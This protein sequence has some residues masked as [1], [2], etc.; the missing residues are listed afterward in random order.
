MEVEEVCDIEVMEEA[1]Q[2]PSIQSKNEQGTPRVKTCSASVIK[3]TTY[4]DIYSNTNARLPVAMSPAEYNHH[5]ASTSGNSSSTGNPRMATESRSFSFI[6]PSNSESSINS[7]LSPR[8]VN[9]V[10]VPPYGVVGAQN[11]LYNY[12]GVYSSVNG[13][14][15][16]TELKA[17]TQYALQENQSYPGRYFSP[18]AVSGNAMYARNYYPANNGQY[19]DEKLSEHQGFDRRFHSRG[20]GEHVLPQPPMLG[21][22]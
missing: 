17:Y 14:C 10:P 19:R 11:M 12:G 22:L 18:A 6:G 9:T 5:V 2:S 20:I 7:Y 13:V 4:A 15:S 16:P 21:A 8:T 1:S 3:S